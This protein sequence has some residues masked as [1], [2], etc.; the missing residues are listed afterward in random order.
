M[1][2]LSIIGTTNITMA[3]FIALVTGV[4]W[5]IVK[6]VRKPATEE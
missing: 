2:V 3:V 1:N 6:A 4:V 5:A